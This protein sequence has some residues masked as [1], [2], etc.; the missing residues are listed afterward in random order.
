MNVDRQTGEEVRGLHSA[1]LTSSSRS[2]TEGG[3]ASKGDGEEAVGREEEG[4]R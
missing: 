1:G 4:T 2:Q 3:R